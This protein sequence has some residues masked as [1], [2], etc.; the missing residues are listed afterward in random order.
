MAPL[1]ACACRCTGCHGAFLGS[2]SAMACKFD[3]PCG[4]CYCESCLRSLLLSRITQPERFPV[5]C[6]AGRAFDDS[7]ADVLL[8]SADAQRYRCA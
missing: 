7:V 6:C 1:P 2:D 3:L 5:A 8:S 4:C